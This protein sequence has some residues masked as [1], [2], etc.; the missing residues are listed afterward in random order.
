MLSTMDREKI[1]AVLRS[2]RD[3]NL[4]G[5]LFGVN[6]AL[7]FGL[8]ETDID[9][10]EELLDLGT[11][12]A[13]ELSDLTGLTTGAVTRVID[14]LEQAGYARRVHDPTDRRRVI[15][16]L[17]PERVADVEATIAR[18][19]EKSASEMGTYSD[20][21]LAVINDFL[22]RMATIRREE[23]TALRETRE[24]PTGSAFEHAAPVG[25][26]R[27]ARLLFKAGAHEL[28]IRGAPEL[29]D[30][31]RAKF[32]GP[33]PQVRLRE[34]TVSI[35]YKGGWQWAFHERRADIALNTALPWEIEIDGGASKLQGKFTALDL[36]SFRLTGG[37][38]KF[39]LTLGPPAGV[40]P[41]R[42][43]RGANHIRIERPTGIPVRLTVRGGA[44]RLDFDTQQVRGLGGG[45]LLQ[46]LGGRI[47]ERIVRV[48][49]AD[50]GAIVLATPG[51]AD[52]ADGYQVEIE[53]GAG[54]ITI[55]E[56][57]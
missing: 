33:A 36:R 25:G 57:G 5:S 38:D 20:A 41:V 40:V 6:V 9:A 54:R 52:A 48:E 28:L 18:V 34:G 21:E 45:E 7:R 13:G 12:T 29:D 49:S 23:A 55:T 17:V 32:E 15:V 14:R 37:V 56:V 19:D 30:L 22:T 27:Q 46:V 42:F 53:G 1:D 16:E 8:S 4:Q 26:L 43:S 47:D 44:G 10:I 11:A 51:F 3:V 31:Y 35:Q 24:P 39:R 50:H 2:L